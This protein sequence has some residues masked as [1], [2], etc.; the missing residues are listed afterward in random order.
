M[1][2][3]FFLV[4]AA[5][6]MILG[7]VWKQLNQSSDRYGLSIPQDQSRELAAIDTSTRVL[8]FCGQRNTFA[9]KYSILIKE[10]RQRLVKVPTPVAGG[11]AAPSSTAAHANSQNS[12]P[13]NTSVQG[14]YGS[15]A[16]SDLV[17]DSQMSQNLGGSVG[18]E[19]ISASPLL[20]PDTPQSYRASLDPSNVTPWSEQFGIF[21]PTSGVLPYGTLGL[22]LPTRRD[23]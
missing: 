13:Y 1:C 14:S 7:A 5:H 11:I 20:D 16:K 10:L 6:I 17:V 8:D 21:L 23:T 15:P 18:Q 22:I 19:S 9:R 2:H 12:S 3:R 4:N